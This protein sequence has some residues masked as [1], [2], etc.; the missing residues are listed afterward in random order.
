MS[1]ADKRIF[2]AVMAALPSEEEI[3]KV[4]AKPPSQLTEADRKTPTAAV[5]GE[6]SEREHGRKRND[7]GR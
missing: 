7:A 5:P 3:L 4:I 1:R 6:I 2:S